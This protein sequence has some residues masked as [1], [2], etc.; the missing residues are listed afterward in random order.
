MLILET[1]RLILRPWQDR[2]RAPFAA[3][4]ADAKVRRY[5]YPS[6]LTATETD[7]LID[8]ANERLMQD[9]FGFL[10]VERKADGVLIGGAGLSRPGPEVPGSFPLEIGWI[11][12]QAHW[13]QGYATEASHRCLDFAWQQFGAECVI[14]YTS[15]VNLPSRQV[16]EKIGMAR[17]ENGDFDDVTVPP[18]HILRPHALYRVDRP[19]Q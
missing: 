19:G 13:R 5:Y 12:G 10:A 9:G 2:D 11:L 3:I 14:G 17:V 1:S 6:L 8:E 18:G 16:M 7:K 4:N 15:S